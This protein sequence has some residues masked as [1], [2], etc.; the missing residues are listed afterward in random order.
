MWCSQLFIGRLGGFLQPA[1]KLAVSEGAIEG[2][3]GLNAMSPNKPRRQE[4]ISTM[5]SDSVRLVISVG[6][7]VTWSRHFIWRMRR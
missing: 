5:D 7:F 6:L 3:S 4:M 1:G 2:I